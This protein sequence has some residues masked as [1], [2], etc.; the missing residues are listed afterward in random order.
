MDVLG[1]GGKNADGRFCAADGGARYRVFSSGLVLF[2]ALP[3]PPAGRRKSYHLLQPAPLE[4]RLDLEGAEASQSSTLEG[5]DAALALDGRASGDFF[6]GSCASTA[7]DHEPWWAVELGGV[8]Q[9]G[10]IEVVGRADCCAE[11]S[12]PFSVWIT[13]Q[14]ARHFSEGERCSDGNVVSPAPDGQQR[15]GPVPCGLAGGKVW[16]ALESRREYLTLCEV[17]VTVQLA[18]P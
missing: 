1:W 17:K 4:R 10:E 11:R 9:V 8:Y 7:Q 2:S 6:E 13:P 15:S 5:A 16:I 14:G 12:N 3:E 18:A